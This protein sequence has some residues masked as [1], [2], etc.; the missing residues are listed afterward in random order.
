MIVYVCTLRHH[1]QLSQA[2]MQLSLIMQHLS[3]KE[4]KTRTHTLPLL[5]FKFS[6]QS[7]SLLLSFSFISVHLPDKLFLFSFSLLVSPGQGNKPE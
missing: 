6:I 2:T 7:Y 5:F 3:N 4:E 1:H